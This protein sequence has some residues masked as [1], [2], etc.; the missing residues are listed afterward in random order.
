[1]LASLDG[2]IA[3]PEG[4]PALPVPDGELHRHF[5][6]MMKQ[7]RSRCSIR[8]ASAPWCNRTIGDRPQSI[9]ISPNA[10]V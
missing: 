9:I 2:Y 3:G 4:G 7:T 8:I 1:M 10:G 5:K 6:E